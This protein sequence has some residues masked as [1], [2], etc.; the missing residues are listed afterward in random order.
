MGQDTGNQ[1]PMRLKLPPV[2]GSFRGGDRPR[3]WTKFRRLSPVRSDQRP[4]NVAEPVHRE[5]ESLH[6]RRPFRQPRRPWFHLTCLLVGELIIVGDRSDVVAVRRQMVD[7]VE[8]EPPAS[9]GD[10]LGEV[11]AATERQISLD[12]RAIPF[13][14]PDYASSFPSSSS[15]IP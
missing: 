13:K 11:P 8:D 6:F 1:C 12:L 10:Q 4:D 7:Q 2:L 15:V 14:Q 5:C 9:R 3:V